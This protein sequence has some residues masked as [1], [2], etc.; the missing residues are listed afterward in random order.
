[1]KYLSA[2]EFY[3]KIFGHKVYKICLDAGCT[4][5]NR[6]GTKDNRG[7]IFC[8]ALGSGEFSADRNLSVTQQIEN[9]KKL[10]AD[11]Q[12]ESITVPAEIIDAFNLDA[13]NFVS[14][15]SIANRYM[16]QNCY[17]KNIQVI[18]SQICNYNKTY[19]F[20]NKFG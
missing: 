10:V 9:A 8:S 11:I 2:N 13:F 3:K 16:E 18:Y 19:N 17:W 12:Q 7:C 15:S 6:D 14:I 20:N 4:C 1:M 5:P